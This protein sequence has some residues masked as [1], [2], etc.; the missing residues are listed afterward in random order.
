MDVRSIQ[1]HTV[2]TMEV[3]GVKTG[4][5]GNTVTRFQGTRWCLSQ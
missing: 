4:S 2:S 5:S 1:V 3:G